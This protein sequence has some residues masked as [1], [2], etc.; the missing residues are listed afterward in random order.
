MVSYQDTED[1]GKILLLLSYPYAFL[2]FTLLFLNLDWVQS[3]HCLSMR[4][5][6]GLVLCS[7]LALLVYFLTFVPLHLLD[8]Q[9]RPN[10]KSRKWLLYLIIR[11]FIDDDISEMT[12]VASVF[13]MLSKTT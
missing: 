13:T 1:F 5:L 3:Y 4:T 2:Q 8:L 6:P 12:S 10:H 7:F 11:V 9:N